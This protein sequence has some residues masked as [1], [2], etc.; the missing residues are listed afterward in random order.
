MNRN[1]ADEFDQ[2]LL[3]L[4]DSYAHGLIERREFLSKAGKFT[5]GDV[6]AAALLGVL[7]PN[8][9]MANQVEENDPRIKGE[10]IEYASPQGHGI[11]KGLLVRPAAGGSCGALPSPALPPWHPTGRP[12][13][14]GYPGTDDE[15][16]EM[17]KPWIRE[18]F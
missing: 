18:N 3:D 1:T 15:G 8:Y 14:G 9:A 4:Y 16:K 2:E 5:A 6:T 17:Q 12:R 13:W 7:S 11:V 10:T